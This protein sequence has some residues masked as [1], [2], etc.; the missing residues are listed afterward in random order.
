MLTTSMVLLVVGGG[1]GTLNTVLTMLTQGRPVLVMAHSGG[2]A[3]D[4]HA[5]CLGG[6]LPINELPA[7]HKGYQLRQAYVEACEEKMRE[8]RELGSERRGVRHG[9][10]LGLG[11][12]LGVW[13]GY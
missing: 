12:G 7:H 13:V 8:I 2:C 6:T 10:G 5:Y 4:I 11:L 9:L 1:P 3:A